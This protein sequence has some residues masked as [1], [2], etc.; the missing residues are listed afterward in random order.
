[1]TPKRHR[2]SSDNVMLYK[3]EDTRSRCLLWGSQL[4]KA[5]E[6]EKTW[7]KAP[8]GWTGRNQVPCNR[9][10]NAKTRERPSHGQH[11]GPPSLLPANSTQCLQRKLTPTLHRLFQK[12]EDEGE[13][14]S[15]LYEASVTLHSQTRLTRPEHHRATWCVSGHKSPTLR[16][17]SL[18]ANQLT[19][20]RDAEKHLLRN[21]SPL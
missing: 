9:D 3:S 18:S 16:V 21:T 4:S 7:S 15:L 6:T 8:T 10:L 13:V 1:M 19:I 11:S 17:D 14:P 20:F 5:A 12:T 2:V